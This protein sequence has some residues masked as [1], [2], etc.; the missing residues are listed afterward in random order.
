VFETKVPKGYLP[1]LSFSIVALVVLVMALGCGSIVMTS[2]SG[3]ATTL[4]S[5]ALTEQD[6]AAIYTQVI[7]QIYNSDYQIFSSQKTRPDTLYLGITPMIPL[8]ISL[9]Y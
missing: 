9:I 1:G 4:P 8:A 2:V 3:T 7:R 5:A 6:Q